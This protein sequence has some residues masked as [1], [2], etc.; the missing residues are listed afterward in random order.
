MEKET[1]TEGVGGGG[2]KH[3]L[4]IYLFFGR[5]EG[6]M[7]NIERLKGEGEMVEN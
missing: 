2:A 3:V 4:G 1:R 5:E 7:K 6:R